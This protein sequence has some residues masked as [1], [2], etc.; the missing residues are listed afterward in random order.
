MNKKEIIALL[1][2]VIALLI[3]GCVVLYYENYQSTSI[4]AYAIS[5]SG[6]DYRGTSFEISAFLESE[7]DGSLDDDIEVT[8]IDDNNNVVKEFKIKSGGDD[9]K[10]LSGLDPGLYT[11]QFNYHGE[12]PYK[13]SSAE[14]KI[15]ITTPAEFE[16]LQQVKAR[17]DDLGD[18]FWN[19]GG[20]QQV[21]GSGY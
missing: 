21:M 4:S 15:N 9:E 7:K 17:D 20:Y 6:I 16:Y 19:R 12:Y 10:E 8:V 1:I 2:L 11:I 5:N 14:K 18:W 3:G 13:S